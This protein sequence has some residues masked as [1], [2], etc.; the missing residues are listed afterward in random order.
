[1]HHSRKL[2]PADL[3]IHHA[4]PVTS[5]PRTLLDIAANLPDRDIER[6]LDEALFVR[7]LATHTEL[8]DMVNR[9]GSHPGRTRLARLLGAH[10]RSTATDSVPAERMLRLIRVAGLPNPQLEVPMLDYRLDFY[11]PAL[12]LAVEVDAYG[13]HGSPGRFEDDRRRDA[14]LLTEMGV[15]VI[16]VTKLMIE[17]RPLEALGVVAR[18]IG[19]REG[20][21]RAR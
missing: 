6:L 4:L 8:L 13:T 15:T 1:V 7:R 18:A 10:S 17:E 20:E 3:R 21:L 2:T 9:A 19:Q 14:R 11:W 5:P 16:R 12:R